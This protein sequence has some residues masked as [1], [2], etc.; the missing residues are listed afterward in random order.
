MHDPAPGLD[1]ALAKK[2]PQGRFVSPQRYACQVTGSG[3]SPLTGHAPFQR[4]APPKLPD[5]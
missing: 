1:L 4:S 3:V 2:V 5:T